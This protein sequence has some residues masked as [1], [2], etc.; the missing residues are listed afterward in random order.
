MDKIEKNESVIKHISDNEN[1]KVIDEGDFD[2]E[3]Q[4]AE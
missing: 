1:S 4:R 2:S 3:E